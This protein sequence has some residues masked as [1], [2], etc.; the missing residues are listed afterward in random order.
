MGTAHTMRTYLIQ[1]LPNPLRPNPVPS[2]PISPPRPT[3]YSSAAIELMGFKK[4]IK[5]EI[6][7]YPSLKKERYFD[8]FSR[9]LFIFAK[10][11][12][13]SKVLDPT[14][15][16]RS[17]PEQKEDFEAKQTFMFSVFVANL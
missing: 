10:S 4:D 14:D 13:C 11:H 12:E 3:S 1:H 2:G 6:A 17:E 16:L 5:R 9:S 8:S 7:A 15:T